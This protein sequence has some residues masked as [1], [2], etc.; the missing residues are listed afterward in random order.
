MWVVHL[1]F[2]TVLEPLLNRQGYQLVKKFSGYL[3]K[4]IKRIQYGAW[5]SW[6]LKSVR[7]AYKIFMDDTDNMQGPVW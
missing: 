6:M 4:K 3:N 1:E 7:Y 5:T 2:W